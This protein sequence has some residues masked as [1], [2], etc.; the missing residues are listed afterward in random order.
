MKQEGRKGQQSSERKT[1]HSL[2]SVSGLLLSIVCCAALIHLELRI[3]KYDRLISHSATF[4]EQME[5]EI[6]RKVQQYHGRWEAVTRSQ[7]K[8]TRGNSKARSSFSTQSPVNA[9]WF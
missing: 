7:W 5:K 2:C 4:C 6:L 1:L 3:Q 8:E 9:Y